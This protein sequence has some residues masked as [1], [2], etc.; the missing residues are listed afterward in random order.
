V[1]VHGLGGDWEQTWTDP[2]TGKCWLRDFLPDQFPNSR[3]MSYGY[4]SAFV[5]SNSVADIDASA[6]ALNNRLDGERQSGAA[7]T[8]LIFVAHSLGGIIVKR[9]RSI[10][11]CLPAARLT[12]FSFP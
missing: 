2:L 11:H 12:H 10:Y 1:A 5:L 7:K 6:M 3:T 8:P 4:D 9:V